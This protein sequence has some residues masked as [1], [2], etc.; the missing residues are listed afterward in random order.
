M[1][2]SSSYCR[3]T[4]ALGFPHFFHGLPLS[5]TTSQSPETLCTAPWTA[6]RK[7]CTDV[8]VYVVMLEE[9]QT[10]LQA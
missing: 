5:I 3:E 9:G 6:E 8:F 7:Q 2:L 4:E 10:N 1:V